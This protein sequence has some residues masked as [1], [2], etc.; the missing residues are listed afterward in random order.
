[1]CTHAA[2]ARVWSEFFIF[3]P[4]FEKNH[5]YAPGGMIS[6]YGPLA[7]RHRTHLGATDFDA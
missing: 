5:K 4:F 3:S 7:R 2:G 6:K 1:M